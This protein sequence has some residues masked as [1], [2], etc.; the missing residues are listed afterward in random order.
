MCVTI[1]DLKDVY[2]AYLNEFLSELFAKENLEQSLKVINGRKVTVS[3]FLWHLRLWTSTMNSKKLPNAQDFINVRTHNHIIPL[4]N[5]DKAFQNRFWKFWLYEIF[6]ANVH[7]SHQGCKEETLQFF[8]EEL[9]R[10]ILE[11]TRFCSR[12]IENIIKRAKEHF[13]ELPKDGDRDI[14]DAYWSRTKNVSSIN[15]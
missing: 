8:E 1:S 4:L 15:T 13:Y 9:K 6:Q 10:L 12:D 2:K 5:S 3:Q 7:L 11:R 14:T